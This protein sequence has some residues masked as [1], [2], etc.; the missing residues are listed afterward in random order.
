MAARLPC[1]V[2]PLLRL[3]TLAQEL[4]LRHETFDAVLDAFVAAVEGARARGTSA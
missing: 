3:E 4:I 1:R 2:V